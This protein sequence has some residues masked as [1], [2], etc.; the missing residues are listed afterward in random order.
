[1]AE[2]PL[3]QE[4]RAGAAAGYRLPG[5]M[6]PASRFGLRTAPTPAPKVTERYTGLR[7]V[8]EGEHIMQYRNCEIDFT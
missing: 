1:M 4:K 6:R 8:Q 7:I 2:V 5:H 3:G